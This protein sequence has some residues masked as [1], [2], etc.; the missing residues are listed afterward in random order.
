MKIKYI[1]TQDERGQHV[2]DFILKNYAHFIDEQNPDI[3]FLTGGD[4]ALMHA[5]NNHRH[6]KVPFLGH[7]SGTLNFSMNKIENL[8]DFIKN[9]VEDKHN[10]EYV[11]V[12]S[13]KVTLMKKGEPID[14]GQAVNEVVIGTSIMGY[15]GFSVTSQD[16]ALDNLEI[17]GCGVCIATEFGSTAYNFNLGCPVLPIG[18]GLWAICGIICNRFLEDIVVAQPI[19]IK[20]VSDRGPISIFLDGRD[21]EI[22]LD[23]GDTLLLE[24]GGSVQIAFTNK[25]EFMRRRIEIASRYRK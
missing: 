5:I 19:E 16:K 22:K 17:Y 24:K 10:I 7:A 11:D 2:N 20:N 21:R 23:K 18:S 12:T 1:L 13:I 14:L 6:L 15:H 4:G 9:L 25:E 3:I 8:K